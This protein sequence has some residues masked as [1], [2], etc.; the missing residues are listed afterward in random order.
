MRVTVLGP[1]E[2]LLSSE[3]IPFFDGGVRAGFPSPAD[4]YLEGSLSLQDMLIE[5]PAATFLI[6]VEGHSMKDAGILDGDIAIVDRALPPSHGRIV[7]AVVDDEFCLKRLVYRGGR[8]FLESANASFPP[9]EVSDC[10]ENKIW[11]VVKHV[12]HTLR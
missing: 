4:D 2:D 9:M 6:K 10:S 11:G 5:H 1:A 3:E 8:C 12:I 7:V